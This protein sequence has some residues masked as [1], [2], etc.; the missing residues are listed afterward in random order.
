M[1]GVIGFPE[2]ER[3][4]VTVPEIIYISLVIGACFLI[5]F[6]EVN[7]GSII[8]INGSV[9]GFLF[10]Y[11]IPAFLHIKCLYFSKGKRPLPQLELGESYE[12]VFSGRSD[13]SLSLGVEENPPNVEV[14]APENEA[15]QS[16][17][18][19]DRQSEER[20]SEARKSESKTVVLSAEEIL[21]AN[22][23]CDVDLNTYSKPRLVLDWILIV[24]MVAMGD[25]K[26]V[27]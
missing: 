25:R 23:C 5:G 14:I 26:S 13:R 15:R 20:Q 19:E 17:L 6:F 16:L 9:I 1:F 18:S 8:D 11:F 21:Y 27:V 3:G 24:T 4:K 10:I 7:I 2:S 12:Q 22:F